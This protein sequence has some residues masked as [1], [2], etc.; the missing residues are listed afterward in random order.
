L[1]PPGRPRIG[2]DAEALAAFPQQRCDDL[3]MPR[4]ATGGRLRRMQSYAVYWN[5]VDGSCF[6]GRL[7]LGTTLELDGAT[8]DGRRLRQQIA[9]EQIAS[10]RYERGRLHVWRRSGAPLRFG[11]VDR[12]GALLELGD[13]LRS[14]L[15][16]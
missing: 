11:S 5:G 9:L 6:S 16:A 15:A 10:I 14:R 13:R 7:S 1:A 4:R 8:G 2:R 12:P 3:R